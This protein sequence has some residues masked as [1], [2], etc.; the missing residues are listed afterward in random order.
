MRHHHTVFRQLLQHVPWDRFD[1]LAAA[2]GHLRRARGFTPRRHLVS[3]LHGALS[4]AQGLR[5]T[6][7]GLSA[8]AERL[9]HAG[10]APATRPAAR[11][12][13]ADANRTRDA[14][15]FVA[16]FEAMVAQATRGL[17]RACDGALH[18]L[19]AT[20]LRLNSLAAAWASAQGGG[21]GG[22]AHVVYD[23]NAGVPLRFVVTAATVNDITVAR[24]WPI[25]PGVTYAFDLGYHDFK[26]FRD[27]HDA[28]CR[29]VT[30]F[31]RNTVFHADE[32]RPIPPGDPVR[33]DRVGRLSARMARSRRN[34]FDAPVR[35]IVVVTDRGVALRIMTNDLDAP[36]ADIAAIYRRR[37]EIELFFRWVKQ[38]LD[39]RSF[40]G[41][42]QNA[43]RIQ[44]AV[45]MIAFLLIRLAHQAQ[46]AITTPLDFLRTV[47]A[48][49]MRRRPV[50]NLRRPPPPPPDARQL[51]FDPASLA[52]A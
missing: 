2:H 28:G 17:R 14:D 30:R 31:K 21:F 40:I 18:L 48:T 23:A 38:T 13:L 19:D 12:T 29:F 20:P 1:R 42:S 22:K 15:A 26:W 36:A 27:L 8:D 41:A 4:G 34:P 46:S 43:V 6:V 24:A 52:Q 44:I 35:E 11:A 47:R 49:L 10:G 9:Y 32:R 16:L 50:T 37:W 51:T 7:T 5:A 3:L 45:A 25:E 39:I 33:S